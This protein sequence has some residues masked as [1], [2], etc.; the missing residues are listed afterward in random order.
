MTNTVLLK[1]S[2]TANAVPAPG[3]LQSGEL[4]INYTDGNLFFKDN[5][6][7]VQN[8]ASKKFITVSGNVTGGN[9]VSLGNI[10]ATGNI[11][12]NYFIGNGSQ[13]T[14][15]AV[16][17]SFGAISVAGSNIVVANSSGAT[18]NFV[19][20]SGI[21]ITTNA[22]TDTITFGGASTIVWEVGGSLGYVWDS[23]AT[24]YDFGLVTEV[25]ASTVY[26]LG[27][28]AITGV[29]YPSQLVLP[30][31]TVSSLPTAAT[32]AQFVYV[33]NDAGGPVPAFSDGTNW[34]RV[35]DRAIVST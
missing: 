5:S 35:T 21:S 17:N 13:L 7:N 6:G 33:T 24:F 23:P 22:V 34:R 31:Y 9:V 11:A 29:F 14:G 27:T 19:A 32:A 3:D 12:G 30:S 20:G 25:P 15:I 16:G 18:V 4:A 26:D 10:S 8:I 1:K 2:N 28:V